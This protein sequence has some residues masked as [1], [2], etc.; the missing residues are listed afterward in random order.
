MKKIYY[1]LALAMVGAMSFTSCS[2]DEPENPAEETQQT[3]TEKHFKSAIALYSI[4]T[5][6]IDPY[7]TASFSYLDAEGKLQNATVSDDAPFELTFDAKPGTQV[8]V[9]NF[10]VTPKAGVDT[11]KKPYCSYDVELGFNV[12]DAIDGDTHKVGHIYHVL[13]SNQNT[14]DDVMNYFNNHFA[15]TSDNSKPFTFEYN[16]NDALKWTFKE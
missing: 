15:A 11:S 6:N 10:V 8:Q 14:F 2:K 12:V 4:K 13:D 16:E 1:I 5:S 7:F 3:D 9:I